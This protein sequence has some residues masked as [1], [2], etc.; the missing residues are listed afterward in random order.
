MTVL[1]V[2]QLAAGYDSARP[3]FSDVDLRLDEGEITSLLG[4]NGAGK[5]TLLRAIIGLLPVRHGTV[6]VDGV[7][8]AALSAR[9]RARCIGYV[10]QRED[11]DPGMSVFDAVLIGRAPHRGWMLPWRRADLGAA[12]DALRQVDILEHRDRLLGELSGGERQ[13]V[14]LARALAQQPAVMLLDEPV[15]HL[16][17]GHQV[18]LFRV[19]RQL[20][21]AG[22]AI[23]MT[24]HDLN[25]ALQWSDRTVLLADG[26]CVASGRPQEVLTP[27]RIRQVYGVR[28]VTGIVDGVPVIR[29]DSG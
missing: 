12:E 15:A 9:Q 22:T 28:A 20:A 6:T 29:Y 27:E 21:T 4:P 14:A 2:R 23:L 13:R 18:A 5:T 3:V 19:L 24:L 17:P 16:D 7:P 25:Q 11:L 26:G 10:P 1:T 8:L